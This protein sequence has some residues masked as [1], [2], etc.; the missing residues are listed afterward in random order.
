MKNYKVTNRGKII[1]TTYTIAL[2]GSY[3]FSPIIFYTLSGVLV[4][5]I[6]LELINYSIE[7]LKHREDKVNQAGVEKQEELLMTSKTADEKN[8][9]EEKEEISQEKSSEKVSDDDLVQENFK[10]NKDETFEVVGDDLQSIDEDIESMEKALEVIGDK[11]L[12]LQKDSIER[13]YQEKKNVIDKKLDQ[14]SDKDNNDVTQ[15]FEEESLLDSLL[16]K[17]KSLLSFR[18]YKI[19]NLVLHKHFGIGKIIDTEDTLKVS[20][21]NDHLEEIIEFEYDKK[22]KIP[23]LD[24]FKAP[25]G[26]DERQYYYNYKK[27]ISHDLVKGIEKIDLNLPDIKYQWN[28]FLKSGKTFEKYSFIAISDQIHVFTKK[29]KDEVKLELL[30]ELLK[31]YDLG[32][33][34]H[35]IT[36]YT[37][38]N[39]ILLKS[40]IKG[41][42]SFE[43]MNTVNQLIDENNIKD[44]NERMQYSEQS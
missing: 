27:D 38:I 16:E 31:D 29:D 43:L 20:F 22:N 26:E 9:K 28:V 5:F 8:K 19:G 7:S 34:L 15:T 3:F 25:T 18:K 44:F 2:L 4:V 41:I 14:K 17:L 39:S 21:I 23:E 24:L 40:K 33:K 36:D 13:Y 1:L 35:E 12:Q 37:S 6:V 42:I 10:E 11:A 32:I 30:E